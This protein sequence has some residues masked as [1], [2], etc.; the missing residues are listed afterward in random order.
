MVYS[1]KYRRRSYRKKRV[2]S[3]SSNHFSTAS[4]ALATAGTALSLAKGI[5]SLIN[6]ELKHYDRSVSAQA[7][8]TTATKFIDPLENLAE[9]LSSNDRT[10]DSIKVRKVLLNWHIS[11]KANT[12]VCNTFRI[13]GFV[14]RQVNYDPMG[15]NDLLT[16]NT[17]ILSPFSTDATGYRVIYDKTITL[18]GSGGTAGKS[19]ATGTFTWTPSNWHTQWAETDGSG[20]VANVKKGMVKF[21]IY[22]DGFTTTAPHVDAYS[23]VTYIDN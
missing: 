11:N 20:A 4:K 6:V 5:K 3:R 19:T 12:Q 18:S 7:L 16:D 21:L 22:C 8:T 1:S 23:R 15:A 13:I 17:N 2:Y 9:G 14:Q 10:G